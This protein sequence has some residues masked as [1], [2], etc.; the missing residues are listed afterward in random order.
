MKRRT[1][2]I[3]LAGMLVAGTWT[4]LQ[5]GVFGTATT[6]RP[7]HFALG[8]EPSFAFSPAEFL[9]YLHGGVGLTRAIDLDLKLGFGSYTYFGADVE[10]VLLPDRAGTPGISWVA[11]AH[12]T[13]HLGF[14]SSLI[15]SNRFKTFSLYGALDADFEV[16]QNDADRTTEVLVPLY[17]DLGVAIPLS[18]QVEFLLEGN[19][20]ITS[21]ANSGLSG[22]VMFYF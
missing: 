17:F 19:I 6:L 18:R 4:P 20:G 2:S 21:P 11:G 5:A 8:L 15:L 10:F 13:S 16:L 14:D 22:G 3:L 9:L 12:G 7:G 1:A